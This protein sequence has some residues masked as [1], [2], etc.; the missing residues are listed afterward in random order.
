VNIVF[1]GSKLF[2]GTA[3]ISLPSLFGTLVD[4]LTTHIAME[5]LLV[6]CL[7]TLLID[8]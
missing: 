3:D 2:K 1:V 6:E 7:Q 4:A 8:T 5:V